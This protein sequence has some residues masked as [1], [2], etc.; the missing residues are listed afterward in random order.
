MNKIKT[1]SYS[2]STQDIYS[3]KINY[4]NINNYN[5]NILVNKKKH[6]IPINNINYIH[7]NNNNKKLRQ[8]NSNIIIVI[9]LHLLYQKEVIL[10]IQILISIIII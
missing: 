3:D 6:Q 5:S 4:K 1:L 7:S 2:N 9:F 8:N 10:I